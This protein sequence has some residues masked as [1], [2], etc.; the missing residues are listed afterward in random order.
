MAQ[1][2]ANLPVDP[3]TIE[4]ARALRDALDAALKAVED[5]RLTAADLAAAAERPAV[6]IVQPVVTPSSS[7]QEIV[8]E[9]QAAR[10][11]LE[12]ETAAKRVLTTVLQVAS[13]ASGLLRPLLALLPAI[14][15]LLCLAAAC[16]GCTTQVG[17]KDGHLADLAVRADVASPKAFSGAAG[18]DQ[19]QGLLA[20]IKATAAGDQALVKTGP[21][22]TSQPTAATLAQEGPGDHRATQITAN[23][24][25]GTWAVVVALAAVVAVVA[26]V[27]AAIV[28]V[29]WS[30]SAKGRALLARAAGKVGR[31]IAVMPDIEARD[32]VLGRVK[33]SMSDADERQT[34]DTWNRTLESAG[35]RVH[36]RRNRV[37]VVAGLKEE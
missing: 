33:D 10:D 3:A 17:S 36:R 22:A 15:L 37:A 16:G 6:V 32:D 1:Q 27:A 5:G 20:P 8:A 23:L 14:L 30:R 21:T 24:S 29:A 19:V 13:A 4:R 35:Q 28:A 34:L 12:K 26:I 11:E 2:P 25:G 7:V 18:G 31:A 9:S